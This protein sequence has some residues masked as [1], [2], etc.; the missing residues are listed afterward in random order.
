LPFF[1]LNAVRQLIFLY[2]LLETSV[3]SR[4]TSQLW[5]SS[6]PFDHSVLH[7]RKRAPRLLWIF[8]F[9]FYTPSP[10]RRYP[11]RPLFLGRV[12]LPFFIFGWYNRWM[13]PPFFLLLGHLFSPRFFPHPPFPS[14]D[15]SDSIFLQLLFFLPLSQTA[16]L[17]FLTLLGTLPSESRASFFFFFFLRPQRTTWGFFF[18]C[19]VAGSPKA[20][21]VSHNDQVLF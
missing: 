18:G 8:P 11:V 5:D 17:T 13:S 4:A 2:F 6:F 21:S 7:T 20:V 1:F 3:N 12:G 19:V 16:H 14:W 15:L 9:F 10:L